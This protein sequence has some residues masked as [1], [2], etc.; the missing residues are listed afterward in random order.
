[1]LNLKPK[2]ARQHTECFLLK[3]RIELDESAAGAGYD[4]ANALILPSQKRATKIEKERVQNV[5]ILTKKQRKHLQ[6]IV[7]KKKKKEGVS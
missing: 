2:I 6:S 3:V 5:K 7:D 1:M 4:E